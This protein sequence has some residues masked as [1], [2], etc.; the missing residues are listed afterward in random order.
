MPN[1]PE[2]AVTHA[3]DEGRAV[4]RILIAASMLGLGAGISWIRQGVHGEVAGLLGLPESMTVRTVVAIGHPSDEARRPK[5]APGEG[6]RPR[7]EAV[8]SDRWPD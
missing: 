8:F 1:A 5:S 6:R 7:D 4:E 3:Y 2:R